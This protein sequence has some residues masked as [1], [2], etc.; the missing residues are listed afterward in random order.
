MQKSWLVYILK[1]DDKSLYCGIT[2]DLKKRLKQHTGKLKGGAKY[3]RSRQP[4]TLVYQ[5]KSLS[6][7]AALTREAEIKK[8]NKEGK[9]ALIKSASSN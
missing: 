5:E 1:C 7:S 8:M 2:N 6:R 9:E 4:C 3:T